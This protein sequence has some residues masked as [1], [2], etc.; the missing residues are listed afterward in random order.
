MIYLII[1]CVIFCACSKEVERST[2]RK[3]HQIKLTDFFPILKQLQNEPK[4]VSNKNYSK[5]SEHQINKQWDKTFGGNN[6]DELRALQQ[7]SDQGYIL[8]GSSYSPASFDKSDDSK[9]EKDFWI[10]KIDENG[11]KQW[12]KT[13]GGSNWDELRSIQ[14]TK[15]D[16]FFIGGTSL[17][18]AFGDKS[19]NSKGYWDFWVIKLDKNGNRQWDMTLGGNNKD[20]LTDS[21]QTSDGGYILGGYSKSRASGDKSNDPRGASDYWVIKIDGTGNR[22]WDSRFG[23]IGMDMLYSIQQTL[24]NGYILGGVSHSG[25]NGDK[26]DSSRGISDFWIVKIDEYGKKQWDKTFGGDNED[27]LFSIQQT[28]DRGYI[29]GGFSKSSSNNDKTESA[30]G[31]YDFWAIK[32]DENGNKQWDRTFGG[33]RYD[34]LSSI[35]QTSDSGYIMGGFSES[36]ADGDKSEN[37]LG[38]YDFWIVK[39]DKHGNKLWD[40]SFGGSEYDKL[41]SVQETLD[42]GYILGGSSYSSTNK[43]KTDK[44]K[45]DNDY[46]IIKIK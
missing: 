19:E 6:W 28:S 41:C 43:D 33:S 9:G 21:K 25:A 18:D 31:G 40:K 29:L 15:D 38:W 12:D 13:F 1:V 14:Q 7:T 39:I 20:W 34:K 36:P 5:P 42:G 27:E 10:V 3:V 24:D 16:G 37:S 4:D 32:I 26:S 8:G 17:S 11:N 30:K 44:S 45:G 23:G 22:Q 2:Q 46:W 35:Q